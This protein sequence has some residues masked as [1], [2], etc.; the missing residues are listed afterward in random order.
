MATATLIWN[1]LRDSLACECPN[2]VHVHRNARSTT[3]KFNEKIV[4]SLESTRTVKTSRAAL[5]LHRRQ[6]SDFAF[7]LCYEI[8]GANLELHANDRLVRDET[9][10][11]KG[12]KTSRRSSP[13]LRHWQSIF[14]ATH[15]SPFKTHAISCNRANGFWFGLVF[16]WDAFA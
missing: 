15:K 13:K 7:A 9:T 6:T 4:L 11:Q 8:D 10:E 14:C 1:Q 3:A 12:T 16:G 2:D 5:E